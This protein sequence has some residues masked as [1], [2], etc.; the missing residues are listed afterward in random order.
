MYLRDKL[1]EAIYG[2]GY[3]EEKFAKDWSPNNIKALVVT[4]NFI[5]VSHHVGIPKVVGLDPVWVEQEMKMA[6]IG[7]PGWVS[8]ENLLKRRQLSC[9]EEVYVEGDFEYCELFSVHDYVSYIIGD[10]CRLRYHGTIEAKI[11][12]ELLIKCSSKSKADP[13][14]AMALDPEI[15]KCLNIYPRYDGTSDLWTE[16][17]VK[18]H[19]LR[20]EYY[21]ADAQGGALAKH[22]ASVEKRVSQGES[23]W[24]RARQSIV[25]GMIGADIGSLESYENFIA[26]TSETSK[27]LNEHSGMESSIP[28]VVSIHSFLMGV[29]KKGLS[30]DGGWATL[31]MTKNDWAQCVNNSPDLGNAGVTLLKRMFVVYNKFGVVRSDGDDRKNVA[32]CDM[33][34]LEKVAGGAGRE[35]SS[36]ILLNFDL[37]LC[38]EFKRWVG[39]KFDK[40]SPLLVNIAVAAEK[41]DTKKFSADPRVGI[42][43]AIANWGSG[44]VYNFIAKL[45]GYNSLSAMLE[46]RK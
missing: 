20:P 15:N 1:R 10:N 25:E 16:K 29:L 43:K 7:K 19:N 28:A 26:L 34:Y 8:I 9:L 31:W 37:I 23:G 4:R 21:P 24:T 45:C 18:N 39:D 30:Q 44:F 6:E 17:W 11:T 2:K 35:E 14:Y 42:E 41:T 46:R 22:F 3:D 13:N 5:F 36:C 40:R 12:T 32:K 38:N 33:R 27:M